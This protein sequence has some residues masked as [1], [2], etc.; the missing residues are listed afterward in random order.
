MTVTLSGGQ[1]GAAVAEAVQTTARIRSIIPCEQLHV[2][3]YVKLKKSDCGGSN[4][5]LNMHIG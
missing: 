2:N 1:C 3:G 4:L 5:I